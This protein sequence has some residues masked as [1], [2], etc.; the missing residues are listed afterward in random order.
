M[1]SWS[2]GEVYDSDID[3]E[4]VAAADECVPDTAT[5]E[6]RHESRTGTLFCSEMALS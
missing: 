2:F 6:E 4:S 1:C 3:R 5:V